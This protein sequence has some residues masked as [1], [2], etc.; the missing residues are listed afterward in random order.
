VEKGL[1]VN[2]FGR[3]TRTEGRPF[4]RGQDVMTWEKRVDGGIVPGV[5]GGGGGVENSLQV[6]TVLYIPG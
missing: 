4:R 2:R 3:E 5:G 6:G 1:I